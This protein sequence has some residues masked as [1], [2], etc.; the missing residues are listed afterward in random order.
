MSGFFVISFDLEKYFGVFDS[1]TVSSYGKNILG[2]KDVVP[3][4]L[5]LFNDYNISATWAFVGMMLMKTKAQLLQFGPKERINYTDS[6]K[7]VYNFLET[8]SESDYK[9]YFEGFDIVKLVAE[10]RNQ[11]LASHTYS[12]SYTLESGF[13]VDVF[14]QEMEFANNLFMHYFNKKFKS[15]IFPRNQYSK[16]ILSILKGL[17]IFTYRG[18]IDCWLH[19]PRANHQ[20]SIFLKTIRYFDSYFN[21]FP[22]FIAKIEFD[23]DKSLINIQASLFL[24]PYNPRFKYFEKYKIRRIKRAM[25]KAAKDGGL[26]HLWLHPHNFGINQKQNLEQLGEIL[27]YYLILKEKYDFVNVTMADLGDKYR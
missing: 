3:K 16:E 1:K 25:L 13:N 8:I 14:K 18:N 17:G 22:K 20:S 5:K 24:R 27:N 23:K 6:R 11:E 2:V 15:I 10:S 7:S 21:L 26:F 4:I 9:L 19:K 12:H